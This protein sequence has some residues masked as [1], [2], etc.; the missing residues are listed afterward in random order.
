[1]REDQSRFGLNSS[2]EMEEHLRQKSIEIPAN[3]GSKHPNMCKTVEDE[4]KIA[5]ATG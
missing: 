5:S 3:S 2:Q 4:K 1:M